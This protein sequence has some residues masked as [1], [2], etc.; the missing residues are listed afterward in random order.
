MTC[1][2]IGILVTVQAGLGGSGAL[3][4]W[5]AR[6]GPIWARLGSQTSLEPDRGST[7]LYLTS[8]F[9]S[10]THSDILQQSLL[11]R[12]EQD[13]KMLRCQTQGCK[14][15]LYLH[16]TLNLFELG[17]FKPLTTRCPCLEFVDSLE[18]FAQVSNLLLHRV[19]RF[20]SRC[21]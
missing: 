9:Q 18:L 2:Y 20:H 4:R 11:N 1:P 15:F 14:I 12:W 19:K 6:L 7:T 13:Y 21:R 10:P 17:R 3:S 16:F 8:V 5:V